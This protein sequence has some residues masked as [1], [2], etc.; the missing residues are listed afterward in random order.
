M[1]D[2]ESFNLSEQACLCLWHRHACLAFPTPL[3]LTNLQQL[4]LFPVE[5]IALDADGGQQLRLRLCA[6]RQAPELDEAQGGVVI[7]LVAA[8]VS[9]QGVVVERVVRFAPDNRAVPG[10]KFEPDRATDEPLGT[11]HIGSQILVQSAVPLSIVDQ[12]RVLAR[13]DFF[14]TLLLTAEREAFQ[15]AMRGVQYSRGRRFIDLARFDTHQAVLDMIDATYAIGAS[16]FIQPLD[17]FYAV[18]FVSVQSHGNAVLKGDFD[19]GWLAR[20]CAGG[21]GV[22]LVGRLGPGIFQYAAFDAAPP[23]VLIY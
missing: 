19:I 23:E 12:P 6:E 20:W 16:Q 10:S 5:Q 4:P 11:L 9:G 18:D 21:P 8:F 1:K 3:L 2:N 13:D 14:E 17:E 7:E 15:G 22:D